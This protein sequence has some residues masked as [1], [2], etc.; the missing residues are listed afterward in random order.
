MGRSTTIVLMKLRISFSVIVL[1]LLCAVLN[2]CAN[3]NEEFHSPY[4]LT[5]YAIDG[6]TPSNKKYK[7]GYTFL[8]PKPK[9]GGAALI[10]EYDGL[11]IPGYD[12]FHLYIE[13]DEAELFLNAYVYE[14]DVLVK[15]VSLLDN[16]AF[17]QEIDLNIRHSENGI[18]T[19]EIKDKSP[20]DIQT[21]VYSRDGAW[22]GNSGR[23]GF[24]IKRNITK[25]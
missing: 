2:A 17:E 22:S 18:F 4:E 25:R 19:I 16:I 23:G 24:T 15:K 12:S 3:I 21:K 20:V 5:I 7:G 1:I 9:T 10:S 6:E 13:G 14:Q 11:G 8:Y